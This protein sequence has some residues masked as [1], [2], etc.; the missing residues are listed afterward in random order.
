[1]GEDATKEEIE[2][3]SVRAI[4]EGSR[5]K[6]LILEEFVNSDDKYSTV[7]EC[8]EIQRSRVHEST[9]SGSVI[10]AFMRNATGFGDFKPGERNSRQPSS[11]FQF[12]KHILQQEKME[13]PVL[14]LDPQ[15]FGQSYRDACQEM[16]TQAS[17]VM[18]KALK[19]L[20][21]NLSKDKVDDLTSFATQQDS[22]RGHPNRHLSEFSSD[23]GF[24]C[25]QVA[26][27]VTKV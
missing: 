6:E 24:T 18:E 1:M 14:L 15:Q 12:S 2:S 17:R 23:E 26:I 19:V 3:L 4:F 11:F 13:K 8:L 20:Y 7:R 5:I 9:V 25:E 27:I 21:R 10:M 16:Q 22:L